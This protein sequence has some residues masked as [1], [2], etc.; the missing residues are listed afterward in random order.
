[1]RGPRAR[2]RSQSTVARQHRRVATAFTPPVSS[3]ATP[4]RAAGRV[5]S[6]PFERRRTSGTSTQGASAIGRVSIEIGPS[7]VRAR[8]PAR[9]AS[10]AASPGEL[11]SDAEQPGEPHDPD[12]ARQTRGPSHRRCTTQ[13]GSPSE[14]ASPKKGPIGNR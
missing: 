9:R 10:P 5:A 11:A 4:E 8:G 13:A 1:M 2:V 3:T 12:E 14:W 7:T 6:T